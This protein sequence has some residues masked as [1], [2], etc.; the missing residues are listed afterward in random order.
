MWKM[1]MAQKNTWYPLLGPLDGNTDQSLRNPQLCNVEPHPN[2][3]LWSQGTRK[4]AQEGLHPSVFSK[5]FRV[6][7]MD[8]HIREDMLSLEVASYRTFQDCSLLKPSCQLPIRY[9]PISLGGWGLM[10]LIRV[11]LQRIGG[12]LPIHSLHAPNQSVTLGA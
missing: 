11:C 2:R 5:I 7:M 6:A 1:A 3:V 12:F 9:L 8:Q 10:D 4:E